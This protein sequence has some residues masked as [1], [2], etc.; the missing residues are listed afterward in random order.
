MIAIDLHGAQAYS[1]ERSSPIVAVSSL[2]MEVIWMV[3]GRAVAGIAVV[4]CLLFMPH[5]ARAQQ[6]SG[7]L[8]GNLGIY[9]VLN[10]NDVIT[11]QTTYG[12]QWLKPLRVMDARL[13]QVSARLDF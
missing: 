8:T 3:R 5:V 4:A 7:I 10:R 6:N 13:L 9:N 1:S 11:V 2:V 12:S